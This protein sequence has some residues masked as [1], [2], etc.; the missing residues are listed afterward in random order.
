MTLISSNQKKSL[1]QYEEICKTTGKKKIREI[2]QAGEGEGE[3]VQ[4]GL[5]SN[6]NFCTVWHNLMEQFCNNKP[7]N[8][9]PAKQS[10]ERVKF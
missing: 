10:F 5:I 7:C 2:V 6:S 9:S 3:T 1:K 4:S 8:L